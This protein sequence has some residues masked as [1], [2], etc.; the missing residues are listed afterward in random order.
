MDVKANICVWKHILKVK[1]KKLM[2]RSKMILQ[3][4]TQKKKRKM[5]QY[6]CVIRDS[7]S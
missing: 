1:F 3:K 5:I 4:R 2:K 6:T 7:D